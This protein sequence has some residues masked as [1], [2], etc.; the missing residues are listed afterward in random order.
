MCLQRHAGENVLARCCCG[1]E[2]EEA[3]AGGLS[4]RQKFGCARV[5][6]HSLI[7]NYFLYTWRSYCFNEKANFKTIVKLDYFLAS[8]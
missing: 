6:P 8:I 3:D 1:P 4:A 5:A 2:V 7:T